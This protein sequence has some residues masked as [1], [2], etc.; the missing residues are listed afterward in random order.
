MLNKIC[1]GVM[2]FAI[3]AIIVSGYHDAWAKTDDSHATT[4][5]PEVVTRVTMSS[6]DTNRIVSTGTQIKDVV[7]SEEKGVTVKVDGKNAFI[8]FFSVE[9]PVTQERAHADTPTEFYIVCADNSV[10]TIIAIP[11]KVPAQTIYLKSEMDRIKENLDVFS[12]VPFE[13]KVTSL[14]KS[15]Y[16]EN[17]PYRYEIKK[18]KG[19]Q[20]IYFDGVFQA[21]AT[22]NIY[23]PGEGITLTEYHV[24]LVNA[25]KHELSEKDFLV[26]P[27]TKKPVAIALDRH[28]IAGDQIARLFIVEMTSEG[29]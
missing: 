25:G 28:V 10:Y 18:I 24:S 5:K 22:R 7:Y 13:K 26:T 4:V 16:Q 17:I 3:I 6:V 20:K 9:D 14:I 1:K 15:V 29:E 12:G 11:R 8:K 2:P 23:I 19:A 21:K 27:L